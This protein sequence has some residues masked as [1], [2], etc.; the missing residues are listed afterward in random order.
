MMRLMDSGTCAKSLRS[1]DL[2]RKEH[3]RRKDF[4]RW[5]PNAFFQGWA[6]NGEISFYQLETKRLIFSTKKLIGKYQISKSSGSVSHFFICWCFVAKLLITC[7]CWLITSSMFSFKTWPI[8]C[9]ARGRYLG[10]RG[11][12]ACSNS[13]IYWVLR[14]YPYNRH[15]KSLLER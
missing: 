15:G 4:S 12:I 1:P 9:R 6:N 14:R 3:E 13:W 7:L 5:W 8:G 10:Q 11:D 2:H